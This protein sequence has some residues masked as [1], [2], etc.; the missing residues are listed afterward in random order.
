MGAV[1]HSSLC[2]AS[3][4]ARPWSASTRLGRCSSSLLFGWAGVEARAGK[5]SACWRTGGGARRTTG[6]PVSGMLLAELLGFSLAGRCQPHACRPHVQIHLWQRVRA[7]MGGW[8][9][10]DVRARCRLPPGLPVYVSR[11]PRPQATRLLAAAHLLQTLQ[12]AAA[13]AQLALRG[14]LAP[15]LLQTLQAAAARAPP[16]PRSTQRRGPCRTCRGTRQSS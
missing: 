10:A 12:A 7:V 16:A 15:H 4:R 9:D 8:R 11:G 5:L 6:S 3:Q 2:A 1:M 13:C 14:P